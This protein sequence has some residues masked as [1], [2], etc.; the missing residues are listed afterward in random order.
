M[1]ARLSRVVVAL[2]LTVGAALPL[3][4]A[5]AGV[6]LPTSQEIAASSVPARGADPAYARSCFGARYYRAEIGRFTTVDPISITPERLL[7][8]QRLNR[9][10]YAINN[11]LRYVDPKGL[12]I[13]TYD[14]QGKELD[15]V[16]Q[17]KWHNFWCGHSHRMTTSTG[18]FNLADAL[19]PLPD[20]QKHTV[21]GADETSRLVSDFLGSQSPGS[22]GQSLSYGE[23][24]G[25]ATDDWNWKVS[26][27]ATFGPHALFMLEGLGQRSDYLGNYAFGYLMN[28]WDPIGPNTSLAKWGGAAFNLY[29]SFVRG[30]NAFKGSAFTG[31]DDPRDFAAINAGAALYWRR[32]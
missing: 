27:N 32:R 30:G 19:T 4:A 24:A 3:P 5:A 25:R 10:A 11:P 28:A 17:S 31:Y 29:D 18:T 16:K 22:S 26:L 7:N 12:D 14:E 9:Y 23:V 21:I 15:R 1:A 8:P 13:I 20:G 6:R 2:A